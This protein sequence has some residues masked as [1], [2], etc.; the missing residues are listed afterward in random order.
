MLHGTRNARDW[1]IAAQTCAMGVCGTRRL[2]IVR[3]YCRPIEL[4][5]D[6]DLEMQHGLNGVAH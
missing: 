6:W 4:D 1:G 2:G 5:D 3:L